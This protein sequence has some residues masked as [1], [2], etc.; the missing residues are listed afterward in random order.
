MC[1]QS[2]SHISLFVTP[3]TV[4]HQTPLSMEFSRQEYWSGLLFLL[5]GIFLTQG[6][7]PRPLNLL[8]WQ[9]DYFTEPPGKPTGDIIN[10]VFAIEGIIYK[11]TNQF[12]AHLKLT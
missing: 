2:F 10:I 1:A 12:V 8:H 9:K 4:A 11:N 5:Q 6:L 3:W 7:N